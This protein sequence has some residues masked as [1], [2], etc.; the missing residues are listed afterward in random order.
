MSDNI[1][2]ST[3]PLVEIC[4]ATECFNSSGIV[5]EGDVSV[6]TIETRDRLVSERES[7]IVGFPS[8]YQCTQVTFAKFLFSHKRFHVPNLKRDSISPKRE[9]RSNTSLQEK[10]PVIDIVLG[11]VNRHKAA[12]TLSPSRCCQLLHGGNTKSALS[13]EYRKI[14]TS[15]DFTG[16]QLFYGVF[17]RAGLANFATRFI[18]YFNVPSVSTV[19]KIIPIWYI[20]IVQSRVK[21]L[22]FVSRATVSNGV[23]KYKH[24]KLLMAVVC[25]GLCQVSRFSASGFP[26]LDRVPLGEGS[27]SLPNV[28]LTIQLTAKSV[29]DT[30]QREHLLPRRIDYRITHRRPTP[31]VRVAALQLV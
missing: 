3:C 8:L 6:A 20:G 29:Y 26:P 25:C 14:A 24:L 12:I 16:S 19:S 11:S 28:H 31:P 27:P 23:L 21:D 10:S 30:G 1:P 4:A 2:V 17:P 22:S 13:A 5:L 15:E 9:G 18:R 7:A